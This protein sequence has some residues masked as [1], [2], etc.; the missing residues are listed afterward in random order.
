[1][2]SEQKQPEIL[3][4]EKRRGNVNAQYENSSI[5]LVDY[6]VFFQKEK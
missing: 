3:L 2:K 4:E 5:R 6:N 1:M